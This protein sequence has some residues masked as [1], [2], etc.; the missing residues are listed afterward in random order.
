MLFA[1]SKMTKGIFGTFIAALVYTTIILLLVVGL[2]GRADEIVIQTIQEFF[3][4]GVTLLL[5]SFVFFLTLHLTRG[6]L[7]LWLFVF[8][9]GGYFI[10]QL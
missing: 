6:I 3:R 4:H 8:F 9:I 1:F 5:V 2:Q 7:I 10:T